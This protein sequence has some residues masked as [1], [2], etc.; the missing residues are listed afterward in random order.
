MSWGDWAEITHLKKIWHHL[1]EE[2]NGGKILLVM[3]RTI[4]KSGLHIIIRGRGALPSKLLDL[5]PTQ[6]SKVK[7]E[8]DWFAFQKSDHNGSIWIYRR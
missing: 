2:T 1:S 6:N 7:L 4:L 8:F 3:A 5:E